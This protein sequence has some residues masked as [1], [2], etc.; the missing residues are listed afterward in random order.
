MADDNLD[1]N[2]GRLGGA[3]DALTN[4]VRRAGDASAVTAK[5]VSDLARSTDAASASHQRAATQADRAAAALRNVAGT[6]NRA[7]KA[8]Y[9]LSDFG[10]TLGNVS[11]GLGVFLAAI[12]GPVGAAAGAAIGSLGNVAQLALPQIEAL[13]DS[14]VKLSSYGL[15]AA[16]GMED[17]RDKLARMSVPA[18]TLEKVL[19][20]N[21]SALAVF[22]KTSAKA[23]DD[24]ASTIG[25]LKNSGLDQE[26]RQLGFFTE[27]VANAMV[28]YGDMMRVL[29]NNES[30]QYQNLTKQTIAY[31]KELDGIARLTGMQ[32]EEAEKRIQEQLKNQRF[33]AT[34][35][36][37]Q[38]EQGRDATLAFQSALVTV[39]KH[40]P[41][42]ER[43]LMA[44]SS[45]MISNSEEA[46]KL[47]R[48]Y[49]G[50]YQALQKFKADPADEKAR[51]DFFSQLQ[52]MAN[53]AKQTQGSLIMA[54]DA[55][56]PFINY[57]DT[58]ALSTAN[59][60]KIA[61]DYAASLEEQRKN[62][63]VANKDMNTLTG[64]TANYYKNMETYGSHL[65]YMATG[66]DLAADSVELFSDALVGVTGLIVN[67]ILRRD[68]R[69]PAPGEVP[70]VSDYA[71]A[72]A[73]N[74]R[75]RAYFAANDYINTV[76]PS[77]MNPLNPTTP[78]PKTT[79]LGL[80]QRVEELNKRIEEQKQKELERK[81]KPETQ[82]IPGMPTLAPGEDPAWLNYLKEFL[83]KQDTTNQKLDQ[84]TAAIDKLSRSM[85]S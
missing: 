77:A 31:G 62:Q 50:I 84:Q 68:T 71:A 56:H 6:S 49:P 73:M 55:M 61:A 4:K 46:Q 8:N 43:G 47:I 19:T 52:N 69:A 67:D 5:D 34:M 35:Q 82:P 9:S 66:I 41:E 23:G 18:A 7:T 27:D 2:M 16:D 75:Q 85:L 80:Q 36:K 58:T 13:G 53:T 26:L 60:G 57:I 10:D 79:D 63:S 48:S 24:L 54:T 39:G 12:G 81:V 22:G 40:A 14:F 30:M 28:S 78:M 72:K 21:A 44:M 25:N 1:D 38:S 17:T 3:L 37:M 15:V 45:G 76:Q 70:V 20:N 51:M 29:G 11:A 33:L 59:Q 74:D 64:T 32:R 83:G 65:Q 42:V